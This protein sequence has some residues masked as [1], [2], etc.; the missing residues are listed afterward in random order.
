MLKKRKVVM[1]P[2]NEKADLG[3]YYMY[4]TDYLG[5]KSKATTYTK[6]RFSKFQHLYIISD[7]EI[8]EDD[9]FLLGNKNSTPFQKRKCGFIPD[10]EKGDRKIIA[11]TDSSLNTNSIYGI[12][13][14][15]AAMFGGKSEIIKLPQIFNLPQPSKEFVEVFVREYNKGLEIKEVLVEYEEY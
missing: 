11:T 3:F 13:S 2:T 10:F 5:L 4:D 14:F 15:D 8:K 1:L 7:E 6:D 12:N 9:W